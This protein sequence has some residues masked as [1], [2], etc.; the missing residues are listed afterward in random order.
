MALITKVVTSTH[1]SIVLAD[2]VDLSA[3][4][5]KVEFGVRLSPS[6]LDS[7]NQVQLQ[8]SL[9]HSGMFYRPFVIL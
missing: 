8:I 2:Y 6:G 9:G 5:M 4:T 1:F 3:L 7:L